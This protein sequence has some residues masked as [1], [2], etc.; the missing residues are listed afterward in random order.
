MSDSYEDDIV[1]WAEGQAELLRL[2]AA[3]KLV[4]DAKLDWANI[5]EEIEDVGRS[6]R[7]AVESLLT[8]ALLHDL[9]AEA[10]PLSRDA[11][12]WR[13]D[14]RLYRRQAR[15]RFTRSMAQRID[16]ASLYGDALAGLPERIDDQPPLPVPEVCP[17]RLDQLLA[18]E[19]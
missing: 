5:A 3:G 7:A 17:V 1:V 8:Q 19:P 16:I 9:K 11:P 15:R 4:N 14:A 2:R 12:T 6:E 13:A 10:W 18:E